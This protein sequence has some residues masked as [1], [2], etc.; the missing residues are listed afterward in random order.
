M[1]SITFPSGPKFRPKT[2]IFRALSVGNREAGNDVVRVALAVGA[3]RVARGAAGRRRCDRDRDCLCRISIRPAKPSGS[4]R[5]RRRSRC[6]RSS[7]RSDCARSPA[8][9]STGLRGRRGRVGAAWRIKP[10]VTHRPKPVVAALPPCPPARGGRNAGRGPGPDSR[11]SHGARDGLAFES[12]DRSRREPVGARHDEALGP[13]RQGLG[14]RHDGGGRSFDRSGGA[15]RAVKPF[16]LYRRGWREAPDEGASRSFAPLAGLRASARR[17]Q[18]H[19]PP[20]DPPAP[21]S[22]RRRACAD[23]DLGYSPGAHQREQ[24]R[25]SCRLPV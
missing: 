13:Q 2:Q 22:H 3:G 8:A 10:A 18:R 14:K 20:S 16:F 9:S 25:S 4:S 1:R 17:A 21:R 11:G 6:G 23:R 5:Q 19:G 15:V 24:F 7:R 12:P